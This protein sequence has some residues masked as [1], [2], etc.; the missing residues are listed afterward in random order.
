M[1]AIS[2]VGL[3]FITVILLFAL[4]ACSADSG[5]ISAPGTG[6]GG[7]GIV[8]DSVNRKIVYTVSIDV[9]TGNVADVKK[10]VLDKTAELGGYVQSSNENVDGG[11]YSGVYLTVRVPTEKLDELVSVVE[12]NS[13]VRSKSVT[14]TDI[15]TEYVNAEAKKL[16]LTTRKSLLTDMLNDGTLGASDRID[17]ISEISEVDVE[18][19]AIDL[20]ITGYDSSLSYSTVYIDI[21]VGTGFFD[22]A[23][24]LFFTL[25]FV[26]GAISVVVLAINSLRRGRRSRE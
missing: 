18:L 26:A 16:A 7:E 3:L 24:P 22:V 25:L 15:T 19:Q 9:E 14:T 5:G 17:V 13:G 12:S 21:Y 2:K 6:S 11:Q 4:T 23:I 8:S 20:L 10:S 1:K